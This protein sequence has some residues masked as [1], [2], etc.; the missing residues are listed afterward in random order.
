MKKRK[1]KLIKPEGPRGDKD[2]LTVNSFISTIVHNGDKDAYSFVEKFREDIFPEITDKDM[3]KEPIREKNLLRRIIT[4]HNASE[5]KARSTS[6]REMKE[7]I[8]SGSHVLMS[9]GLPNVKIAKTSGGE[10][11]CFDGH[12]SL[13]A[14][15]MAGKEYLEEVPHLLVTDEYGEGLGDEEV[16]AFF[17]D[18]AKK[19]R[20]SDW[21]DYVISWTN[22]PERQLEE[23]EQENMG[24]LLSTL[25]EDYSRV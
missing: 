17:G 11:V 24:D 13:L 4:L 6:F 8:E 7:K 21:R 18:H 25:V 5:I 12:H 15:M 10:L 1:V 23:R 20:G 9:D 19:L 2:T 3:V 22:P 14:Y 16:H